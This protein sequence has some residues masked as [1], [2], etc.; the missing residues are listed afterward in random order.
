MGVSKVTELE[1]KI[2]EN[3]NK[4][5]DE[6]SKFMQLK[7]EN[8]KFIPG[9]TLIQYSGSVYGEEEAKAFVDSFLDG[10][11]GLGPKGEK[12]ESKLAE[13]VGSG[14]GILTNS[15][16]SAGLLTIASLC[17]W[18]LGEKKFKQGEEIIVAGN[19]F[20][21]T[22]N[23][24]VLYGLMPVFVDPELGTYNLDTNKIKEAITP[25]TRAMY[26]A[27]TLGNPY[28]MYDLESIC[29]KYGLIL[30]EDNCDSL[31]SKFDGKMTGSFGDFATHSFYPAHH[32]T[33]GEGGA[34]LTK[35]ND[36]QRIIKILREWGRGC[37]CSGSSS[38]LKPLGE[39]GNR[40]DYKLN[41]I[42]YDHKY[43][44]DDL[45][46]NLKPLEFQAAMGLEQLDRLQKFTETRKRN[47]KMLDDAFRK[48]YDMFILPKS[49]KLADPSWFA[50]P[51]TINTSKIDR[52][53]M[54]KFFEEQ[55]IQTR[56]MFS[57]NLTAHP[58][59]Q[60]V[61]YR[62]HG[63]LDNANR[64]LK[65]SFF[66]GV[67]PGITEEMMSYVIKTLNDFMANIKNG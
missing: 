35:S 43:I 37:Y 29:K 9:K 66:L 32:I 40:F 53:E 3:R 59:Y 67:Y 45:G 31:G 55:K 11:F 17:S 57:G 48:Y 38:N 6:I 63:S 49:E 30:I 1:K 24:I 46:F 19:S 61:N 23:P 41:N 12:F 18:K 50:Y 7:E 62:I 2:L 4:I 58:A 27:H 34:V 28:N 64:T 51:V 5:L 21:T 15:G 13:I 14:Y 26:L 10:W 65:D 8:K 22:V 60:N 56:A 54:V 36:M 39:C 44:F 25:K 42:S 52:Y 47:F 16:S 20:P 33:T